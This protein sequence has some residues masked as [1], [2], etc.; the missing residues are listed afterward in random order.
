[1]AAGKRPVP[2]RTRKLSPP[3]PMVLPG[4]PGGRVGHRRATFTAL[5]PGTTTVPGL[6]HVWGP[7]E[8]AVYLAETGSGDSVACK[9]DT[10]SSFG[11]WI[12]ER[13]QEFVLRT[14]EERDIR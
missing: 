14:L 10:Y 8:R 2:S 5:R 6:K 1:M 13:Q 11:E 4:G 9:A 7:L 12:M 3:A